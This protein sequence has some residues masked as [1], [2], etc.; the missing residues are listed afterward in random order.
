MKGS[1]ER[2]K[3]N[4]GNKRESEKERRAMKRVIYGERMMKEIMRSNEK[5]K[6]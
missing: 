2:S 4:K 6:G 5:I 1:R 3:E